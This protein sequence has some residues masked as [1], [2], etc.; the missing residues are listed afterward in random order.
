MSPTFKDRR[1]GEFKITGETIE[2]FP[3]AVRLLMAQMIVVHAY[4]TVVDHCMVYLAHSP[5]FPEIKVGVNAPRYLIDLNAGEWQIQEV[6]EIGYCEASMGSLQEWNPIIKPQS[7]GKVAI[8][9]PEKSC[10]IAIGLSLDDAGTFCRAMSLALSA[11]ESLDESVVTAGNQMRALAIARPEPET[12][13][14]SHT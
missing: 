11:G 3:F 4:F 6:G 13:I 8:F 12:E 7:D 14:A 10:E 1:F 2:Q 9:L 5:L